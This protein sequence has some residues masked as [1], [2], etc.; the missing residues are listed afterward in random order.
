MIL[1][2][3]KYHDAGMGEVNADIPLSGG[4]FARPISVCINVNN[5]KRLIKEANRL[6]SVLHLRIEAGK[7]IIGLEPACLFTIRDDYKFFGL[8]QI[9]EKI[10]LSSLH[11]HDN[12]RII[13]NGFSCRHQ[14]KESVN[15]SATHIVSLLREVME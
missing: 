11:E 3:S 4:D 6:L 1:D 7:T 13:A 15:R 12:A 2:W 9:E 5:V 14:I 8:D 10:L